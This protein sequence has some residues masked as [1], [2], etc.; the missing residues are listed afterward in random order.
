M[1][2]YDLYMFVCV[3][4][5]SAFDQ[6]VSLQDAMGG[7]QRREEAGAYTI[8]LGIKATSVYLWKKKKSAPLQRRVVRSNDVDSSLIRVYT[9]SSLDMRREGGLCFIWRRKVHNEQSGG[10]LQSGWCTGGAGNTL[11]WPDSCLIWKPQTCN[12]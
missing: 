9:S 4:V 3:N 6:D 1:Y 10:G 2:V 11:M 7:G 12:D 5:Y 8:E